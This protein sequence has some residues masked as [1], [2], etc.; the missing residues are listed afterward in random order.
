MKILKI[1]HHYYLM[2][3]SNITEGNYMWNGV[4]M[5][6]IIKNTSMPQRGWKIIGTTDYLED[7]PKMDVQMLEKPTPTQ[8]N[9]ADV[10]HYS[11]WVLSWCSTNKYRKTG[12]G[13]QPFGIGDSI[14]DEKLFEMYLT[15]ISPNKTEWNDV[16][17]T[18]HGDVVIITKL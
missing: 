18:V 17:A 10:I 8:F 11:N 15:S 14:T 3:E 6:R 7:L 2:E 1:E 5:Y 12:D 16:E 4:I 13:V 9:S